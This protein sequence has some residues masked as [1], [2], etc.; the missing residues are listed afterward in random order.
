[1]NIISHR[2]AFDEFEF[3]RQSFLRTT[4]IEALLRVIIRENPIAIITPP[5]SSSK[6][7]YE[8]ILLGVKAAGQLQLT[9]VGSQG[10][11]STS[12]TVV[13]W[14]R[15]Q[16]FAQLYSFVINSANAPYIRKRA[17]ES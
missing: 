1:M 14:R 12:T 5:A 15:S 10:S 8:H 13:T 6:F 9:L 2:Q 3:G 17:S 11:Y 16:R 4:S 7:E